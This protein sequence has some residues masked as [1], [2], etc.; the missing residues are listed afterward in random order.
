MP[1]SPKT[2]HRTFR[3]PDDEWLTARAALLAQ[4]R[5][6]TDE[7]RNVL[8]SHVGPIRI[9]RHITGFPYWVV[10]DD[11]APDDQPLF[12]TADGAVEEAAR[13]YRLLL[14]RE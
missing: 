1:D 11:N 6:V 2:P 3:A 14:D 10:L 12:N 4:G 8:R 13:R 9:E 5:S 7:L